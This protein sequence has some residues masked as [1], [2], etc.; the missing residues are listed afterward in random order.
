[1]TLT[2]CAVYE[3]TSLTRAKNESES[4]DK[5]YGTNRMRGCKK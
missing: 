5:F 2:I 3:V 1:M 4:G